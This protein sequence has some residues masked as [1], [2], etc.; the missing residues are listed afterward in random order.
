M[1]KNDET[2]EARLHNT[3]YEADD[4]TYKQ[5]LYSAVLMQNREIMSDLMA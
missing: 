1:V 5:L 2:I 4:I 3:R